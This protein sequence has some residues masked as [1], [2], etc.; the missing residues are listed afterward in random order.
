M[1]LTLEDETLR[2]GL[3]NESRIFSLDEKVRIF[4]QLVD[5]GIKRIQVGSF[6][7][8]RLVPQMANTDELV[9][10][11]TNV[12]ED[13]VLTALVL[14]A[15]GL[16]R[17]QKCGLAHLSMSVS[18]SDS[19]SRKNVG[20]PAKTAL[21]EMTALIREA[22]ETGLS[23]RAGIQCAFGCVY[24]GEI[25]EDT[26]LATAEYLAASGASEINLADTTGMAGPRQIRS[27]LRR[28]QGEFPEIT[29][30]LHLHNTRGLGLVNTLAAYEEGIRLFDVCVG[31]LGGCPF[32][33]GAGGNV[34]TEDAVHMF[35]AAGV[36]TGVDLQ[37]ICRLSELL[38]EM[39][40]RP[41]A[42]HMSRVLRKMQKIC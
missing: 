19:H 40:A 32:V 22:R 12:P 4:R 20:R 24:E 13:V 41:L 14:N 34:P 25:S 21:A 16:E 5:S 18:A 11:L 37:R 9:R 38:E 35:E 30:S 8:P 31:G 42:G 6:V 39:L 3:Q 29:I 33:D 7:H 10:V 15:K 27:L 17:A 26:V 23:V 1:L 36:P 2:D 28:I